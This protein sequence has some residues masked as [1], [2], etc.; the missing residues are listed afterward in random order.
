M[1]IVNEDLISLVQEFG[2]EKCT[3]MIYTYLK[4]RERNKLSSQKRRIS[5]QSMKE[6]LLELRKQLHISTIEDD[7][8]MVHS[9]AHFT[10]SYEVDRRE[11]KSR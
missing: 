10:P 9:R 8:N 7:E 5:V 3:H 1:N 11:D 2:E 4:T 6:E